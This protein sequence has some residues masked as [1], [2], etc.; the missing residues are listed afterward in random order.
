MPSATAVSGMLRA[1]S[2]RLRR[3]R[4]LIAITVYV[5]VITA[6]MRWLIPA[7][8]SRLMT[9]SDF[10][11]TLYHP[12]LVSYFIVQIAPLLPGLIG[13][14][15]LLESREDGTVKASVPSPSYQPPRKKTIDITEGVTLKVGTD[16]AL[17]PRARSRVWFDL[18]VRVCSTHQSRMRLWP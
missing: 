2:L 9:E 16:A 3:D 10:D 7:I 6:V 5:L 8:T 1:D 4:F 18:S 15:L 11:L 14:F 12:L 13:G 17:D